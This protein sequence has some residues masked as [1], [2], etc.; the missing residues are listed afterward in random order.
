MAK[1]LRCADFG[2]GC[3]AVIRADTEEDL[4]RQA[5]EHARTAHDLPGI[6]AEMKDLVRRLIREE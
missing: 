5:E 3:P 6:P 4:M 1:V 2:T